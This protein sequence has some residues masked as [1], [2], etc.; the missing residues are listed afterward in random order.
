MPGEGKECEE[1]ESVGGEEV[2][3]VKPQW[4]KKEL[5]I[6]IPESD[7]EETEVK[8]EVEVLQEIVL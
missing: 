1:L 5:V 2:I 7:N 6:E 8:S 3:P 4:S